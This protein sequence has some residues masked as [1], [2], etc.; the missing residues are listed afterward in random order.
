M[1]HRSR[2]RG[3]GLNRIPGTRTCRTPLPFHVEQQEAREGEEFEQREVP[4]QRTPVYVPPESEEL[5]DNV[6]GKD[7]LPLTLEKGGSFIFSSFAHRK[8]VSGNK[9][10]S[11]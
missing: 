6:M 9:N 3:I 7:K 8:E 4:R 1:D 5:T 11:I 10:Q 2:P